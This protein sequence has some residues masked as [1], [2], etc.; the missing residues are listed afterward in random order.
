MKVE[1]KIEIDAP[2][3]LVWEKISR[4]T[5]IQNWTRTVNEA[6]FHTEAERGLGAGRTC[7]VPGLGTLVENVLEWK[8]RESYTLSL[9]GL[10][11]F[12]KNAHG[13][14]RLEKV[15]DNRTRTTTF[16]NMETGNWPIGALMERFILGPQINK[17][18]KIVQSE[19]K[20]YVE[21]GL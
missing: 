10:S 16:I 12:V 6:H 14:W 15:N 19:F 4:L 20:S 21:Q 13:G 1:H 2:L 9:E 7:D 3:N 11:F 5:D 8:E 17:T 18:I